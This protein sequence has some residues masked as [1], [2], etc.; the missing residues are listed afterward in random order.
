MLEKPKIE[1]SKTLVNPFSKKNKLA[2]G[3]TVAGTPAQ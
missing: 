2:R 3:M 1:R